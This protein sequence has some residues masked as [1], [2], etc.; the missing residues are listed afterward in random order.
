MKNF[1]VSLLLL[2][3]GAAM[4]EEIRIGMTT[5]LSGPLMEMGRN[6]Q[7]GIETYLARVNTTDVLHGKTIRLIVK[8]DGY[9]PSRAAPNMRS[10]INDDVI[11]VI[12][13]VGTPTAIVT[14]PI[15]IENK[16]L[17]FGA[18]TGAELLRRKP[19][20][21]YVINYRASYLDEVAEM[22]NGLLKLG[23]KPEEIA[24]FTQ[25]DGYGDA[26]YTGAVAALEANGFRNSAYLAH[27]RY[28]RNTL[29]VEDALATILDARIEPRAIIMAG[30]YAPSAKFI[31]LA[32]KEIPGLIF[33]NLSFVGSSSLLEAL[34]E[35]AEGVIVIQVVPHFNAELPVAYE[36]IEDLNRHKPGAQPNF[37][38]FE[39]YIIA[40]IFTHVMST[41]KQDINRENLVDAFHQLHD[42]D[43]G[44]GINITYTG[45][46]HQA[47]HKVWPMIIKNGKF[48]YFDWS[49]H[50]VKDQLKKP[51]I[52]MITGRN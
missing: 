38:S 4:A 47:T 40:K 19:P 6:M 37:V 50:P 48:E 18:L 52:S 14:V 10:L 35:D 7:D 32:K 25:R 41:I 27:G 44:L 24:F 3:S 33:V 22:I 36:Y 15:A 8:D 34:G 2:V 46:N 20:E 11:A 28:T 45:D 31:K 5:A 21:R 16:I 42:L 26:G 39:G 43:I 23:I 9:E 49:Y 51:A 30:G 17:L 13:N 29:N 12:G 1:I